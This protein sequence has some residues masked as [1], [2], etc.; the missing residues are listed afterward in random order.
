MRPDLV[1]PTHDLI[2]DIVEAFADDDEPRLLHHLN[3]IRY[4]QAGYIVGYLL[5]IAFEALTRA[6]GNDEAVARRVMHA[7]AAA[8]TEEDAPVNIARHVIDEARRNGEI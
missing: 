5:G 8:V 6:A 3:L 2:R 1:G 4:D 7:A